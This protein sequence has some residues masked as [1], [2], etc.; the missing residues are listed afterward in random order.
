M[1]GKKN[2]VF[3]LLFLILTT[4]LGPYMVT[5]LFPTVSEAQSA[6]HTVH[7]AVLMRPT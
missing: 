1:I 2:I 3:G 4:G 6:K 7:Y 5:Q